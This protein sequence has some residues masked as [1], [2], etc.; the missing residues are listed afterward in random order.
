ML[1]LFV[2]CVCALRAKLTLFIQFVIHFFLLLNFCFYILF[3]SKLTV[4]YVMF[5]LFETHS[6]FLL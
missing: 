4:D 6:L 1:P 2:D 3:M 5:I